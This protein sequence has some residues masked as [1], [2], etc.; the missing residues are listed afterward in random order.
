ARPTL[1]PSTRTRLTALVRGRP[2]SLRR[3]QDPAGS[4]RRRS[5]RED[6]V[7]SHRRRSPREDP[8]G[9][10]RR[11]S[12]REDP[13]G[14]RCRRNSIKPPPPIPSRKPRQSPPEDPAESCV[15]AMVL[16]RRRRAVSTRAGG[17]EERSST[18]GQGDP[19]PWRRR[20]STPCCCGAL[21]TSVTRRRRATIHH[22]PRLSH[23]CA[24]G[25]PHPEPS[26]V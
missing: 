14:S 18:S 16:D 19:V 5:P 2:P 17:L 12:P 4:H 11:R 23:G 22:L 21:G 25:C 10:H 8:A 24:Q 6:P 20:P 13:A 3:R 26:S 9:S 7:G 1:L 15:G